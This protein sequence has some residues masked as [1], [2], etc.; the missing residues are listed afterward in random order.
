MSMLGISTITGTEDLLDSRAV[1]ARI[2][3]LELADRGLDANEAEELNALKELA[4]EGQLLDDWWHGVTL[5]RDSYFG[6][7]AEEY[8]YEVGAINRNDAY[9]WPLGCIDWA[10]AATELQ[11]SY[12]DFEFNGV[13][14]WA[15]A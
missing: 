5:I 12:R 1:E 11:E 7:Y 3:Y 13:T 10:L 2:E 8:A 15:R 6:S 14:Y 9:D 4:K